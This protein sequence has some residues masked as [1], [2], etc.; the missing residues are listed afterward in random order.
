MSESEERPISVLDKAN[1]R[2]VETLAE[3]GKSPVKAT[4]IEIILSSLIKRKKKKIL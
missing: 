1:E 2:G 4:K 3:E